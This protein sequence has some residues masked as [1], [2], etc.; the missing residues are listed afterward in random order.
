MMPLSAA[1]QCRSRAARRGVSLVSASAALMMA[2]VAA[3]EGSAQTGR[4]GASAIADAILGNTPKKTKH[5]EPVYPADAFEKR[6]QGTVA[7]MA[8]VDTSGKVTDAKVT[9]SVPLLDAAAIAA[10]RQ[11]EY[12]ARGLTAPMTFMVQVPFVINLTP[13]PAQQVPPA[14]TARPAASS[15]PVDGPR[16]P[17]I[18]T[19]NEGT[20]RPSAPAAAPV[21]KYTVP[22]WRYRPTLGRMI[23]NA[24]TDSFNRVAMAQAQIA[25]ETIALQKARARYWQAFP[26]GPDFAA[27][28]DEF[29]KRLWNK[30][31][32]HI[33]L[34]VPDG[35]RSPMSDPDDITSLMDALKRVLAPYDGGTRGLA[36]K[37]FDGL[38][39]T[40][41]Y[42]MG[43]RRPKDPIN[44]FMTQAAFKASADRLE[45]YFRARDWAEF[46]AS[47]LDIRKYFEPRTYAVQLIEDSILQANWDVGIKRPAPEDEAARAYRA[48]ADGLGESALVAAASKVLALEQKSGHLVKPLTITSIEGTN[49]VTSP[50]RAF[51]LLLYSEPRGAA[52]FMM[53]NPW[54]NYPQ[55]WEQAVAGYRDLVAKYGEE[56]VLSAAGRV[57]KAPR[58][59]TNLIGDRQVG[60]WFGQF[61]ADPKAE[62]PA[63]PRRFLASDVDG[64]KKTGLGGLGGSVTVTGTVLEVLPP[65]AVR[66]LRLIFK[67]APGVV[68]GQVINTRY[69][70]DE[71]G[72]RAAQLVG[73]RIEVT[74]VFRDTPEGI[75][76]RI[77]D[78]KQVR[79]VP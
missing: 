75:V 62:L 55:K 25:Q 49:T 68:S 67:E 31:L 24:A 45:A 30:D 21:V 8:T 28:Q 79:V 38:V 1:I 22:V 44:P 26:D 12:D 17:S 56:R 51:E 5:V 76:L 70:E 42:E 46:L 72:P 6:I 39:D 20:P 16:P 19:G 74:A 50:R 35:R 18:R 23:L 29:A 14:S 47:G 32:Y 3:P 41:R 7:L 37:A 9:R 10:V 52:I 78:T 27:A 63:P 48:M 2:I 34:A 4:P 57:L 54:G 36:A 59:A 15:S 43:A 77:L 13:G 64:L 71:F 65:T 61:M 40:L 33:F 60:Y 73:K 58:S 53:M 11:W 66:G 69:F